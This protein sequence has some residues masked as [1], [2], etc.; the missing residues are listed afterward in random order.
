MRHA[1]EVSLRGVI[2]VAAGLVMLGA[3]PRVQAQ[4]QEESRGTTRAELEAAAVEA[5]REA[6]SGRLSEVER[7]EKRIEAQMIRER[8]RDGDLQVGDR[9]ALRVRGHETLSD[10]FVVRAGRTL[11]IAELPAI[12]V[13]G[14]LRSELHDHL[15]EHI[16]RYIRDPEIEAVP[17]VRVG[18]LGPVGSPGYY[19]VPADMLLSDV[20]MHAGGPGG[21]ADMRRSSI[22]RGNRDVVTR[23]GFA[24]ALASGM[25]L[26]ELNVR[27]GDEL[28]IGER[29]Q[30]NWFYMAQTAAAVVGIAITLGLIAR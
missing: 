5:E 20:I 25:T 15:T 9:V 18:I 21:N 6:A 7:E 26:D 10:T 24:G 29:R 4:E 22:R 30:R 8:L 19:A 23:R 12:S 28:V 2:L 11:Q 27:A 16:G 1:H 13:Q 3:A 17:L 14:V